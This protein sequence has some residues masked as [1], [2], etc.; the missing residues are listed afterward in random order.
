PSARSSPWR[1]SSWE[2][3]ETHLRRATR[4]SA[5]RTPSLVLAVGPLRPADQ[6]DLL[7][8]D[9]RQQVCNGDVHPRPRA[10][11]PW[12]QAGIDLG[13]RLE[14]EAPF[15]QARVRDDQLQLGILD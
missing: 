7:V 11:P 1:T 3:P 8:R 9:A 5:P 10:P 15:H 12:A 13:Q 2:G 4:R 14:R 6:L